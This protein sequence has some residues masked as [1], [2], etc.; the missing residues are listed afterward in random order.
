MVHVALEGLRAKIAAHEAAW[1][2]GAAA[3]APS[4]A[5]PA[6]SDDGRGWASQSEAV[7]WRLMREATRSKEAPAFSYVNVKASRQRSSPFCLLCVWPLQACVAGGG[8]AQLYAAVPLC[9]TLLPRAP[10][11]LLD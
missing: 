2:G 6:G 1:G 3:A 7:L 4:V 10:A 11:C 9:C 5:A 8:W